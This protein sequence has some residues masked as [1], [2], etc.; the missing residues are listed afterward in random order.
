VPPK[1]YTCQN[2]VYQPH[3]S[4]IRH[5]YNRKILFAFIIL[6]HFQFC[7]TNN[8]QSKRQLFSYFSQ[9]NFSGGWGRVQRLAV[10]WTVRGSGPCGGAIFRSRP[11]GPRSP[12]SFLYKRYQVLQGV[13]AAAS[14][15]DLAPSLHVDLS[16]ISAFPLWLQRHVMGW[17]QLLYTHVAMLLSIFIG[18]KEVTLQKLRVPS[19][20]VIKYNMR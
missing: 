12:P 13:K 2:N 7:S 8:D 3:N 15:F 1:T 4:N 20:L 19:R 6:S 5:L 16:C 17:P 11:D 9:V 18:R 10:G 14:V